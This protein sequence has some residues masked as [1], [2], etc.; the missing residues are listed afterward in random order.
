MKRL[1]IPLLVACLLV[2]CAG[3]L[4]G[5]S[6]EVPDNY[7]IHICDNMDG[8]TQNWYVYANKTYIKVRTGSAVDVKDT[9][10][11][12]KTMQSWD[13]L[14]TII[15]NQFYS[16]D[17]SKLDYPNDYDYDQIDALIDFLKTNY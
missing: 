2:P 17:L 14:K 4:V 11:K 1:F 16:V 3:L 5:C 13:D 8:S 6:N 10:E 7:I 9:I 12:R 15:P